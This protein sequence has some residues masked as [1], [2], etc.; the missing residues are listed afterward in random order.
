MVRT[1]RDASPAHTITDQKGTEHEIEDIDVV[2]TERRAF[3]TALLFGC[4]GGNG[5]DSGHG[6]RFGGAGQRET[7]I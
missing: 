5:A 6:R 2:E 4:G 3:A 7:A 1:R